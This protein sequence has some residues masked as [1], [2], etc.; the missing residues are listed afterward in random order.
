MTVHAKEEA[1]RRTSVRE[2]EV[3][4]SY[5]ARLATLQTSLAREQSRRLY[6]LAATITISILTAI[7]LYLALHRGLLPIYVSCL[8]LGATLFAF[9]HY[10]LSGRRWRFLAQQMDYFERGILRLTMGWQGRGETGLEFSRANHLYEGDLNVLGEGS[11]FQLL[12]TTRSHL[13]SERLA[14]YL[15]DPVTHEDS[16][17]R[18]C[19]VKELMAFS[20]HR[21]EIHRLGDYRSDDCRRD[22]FDSW[23]QLA[24][25]IVPGW[26]RLL[27]VS[28]TGCTVI[29]AVGLF[30]RAL[31]AEQ[32]L[33]P[34][35]SLICFQLFVAGIYF[36]R[37]RPR[38]VTLRSL[39][40]AFTVLHGGLLLMERSTFQAPKLQELTDRVRTQQA[41]R[42]VRKMER[43][44]RLLD[45]REKLG[46]Y[47]LAMFLAVGTQLVFATDSWRAR[48]QADFLRWI[49]AWAEFEALQALAGY[50]YE[51]PGMCFPELLQ[52][53]ALFEAEQLCHPL[54]DP[55][56][57][58]PND[59]ALNQGSRFYLVSGSNMAGK[60]TFLR[61]IGL[62]AVVALA[63]GPVRGSSAR[64]SQLVVCAS[65]SITDSLLEGK[66]KFLAEVQRLGAMIEAGRRTNRVLFLIDEILSGTNSEDRRKAAES[67]VDDLLAVGSV[68]AVSTHDLALTQIADDPERH[69]V[70]VHMES[71]RSDDPLAFDY[72]V[73]PGVSRQSNALEI[74]RLV[75]DVA[76]SDA[77]PPEVAARL[78]GRT[79]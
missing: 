24:P 37:T 12:S 66:S 65:L 60:S 11:L 68:G 40:S 54:L 1:S 33:F 47:A 31:P 6:A 56:R 5:K 78:A 58:V 62:N 36:S 19:A 43:L 67:I 59:V 44:V 61:A 55:V 75:R 79:P 14:E 48:Y 76:T 20:S 25:L 23:F 8:G 3:L 15:L 73:K 57:C 38:L 70:L 69:G 63:G 77:A 64:L 41:S 74:L 35:L 49:D 21:E 18:Q 28:S 34:L 53:A 26:L 29:L 39:T 72:R 30:S 7:S 42:Q 10:S 32:W 51:Q 71:N 16:V 27:L 46:F 52:S 13:G 45:Q 17:R 50:A 22:R 9:Q 4:T 2:D